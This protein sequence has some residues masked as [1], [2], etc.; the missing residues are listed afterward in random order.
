MQPIRVDSGAVEQTAQTV[1]AAL[2]RAARPGPIPAAGGGSPIDAAAT[3]L[4]EAVGAKVAT[5][6]AQVGPKSAELLGISAAAVRQLQAQDKANA[7]QIRAV[8]G[9]QPLDNGW[10]TG[11][12]SA[13]GDMSSGDIDAI[14]K[15]NRALLDSMEQEYRALPDGQVKTDRLADIAGIREALKVPESHLVYL[16]R[17]D[18]PAD[19]IP[20]ATAIGD[21][22]NAD[23]VSVTV[24]GVSGA[25]RH[26]IATMTREAYGLRREAQEIARVTGDSQN[27][28]TIAW[29]GYQP[30]PNL[31]SLQ[32]PFDDLAK[33]GAPKLESFLQNLNSASH[34]PGHT[35]ALF[36]HS[37]GSLVSGIALKDGA[38]SVVDN[39]VMY[40]SPGFEA[41]SPAKLGMNDHNFFVMTAP[42]DPIRY[43]A[44]L[45]PL[46]GWGSDPNEVI[47][48][49][50]PRYRF[51]HLDT[52]AGWV[53]LGG[54]Q[55]YKT[56][57]HGHSGY[58]HDP[59]QQMTGF[60]L[61][62]IL[63]NRPD[64]AVRVGPYH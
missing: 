14:D 3:A 23:H 17:P 50:G 8:A 5:L 56:G 51:T 48:G 54:Q 6:S 7:D 41:T 4:A 64:L 46:H 1:A 28:S 38:S 13:P 27:V 20:A 19:M 26:S 22:F 55:I 63:L 59:M 45:A 2:T 60:N 34:N 30:P 21:P 15:A 43:V 47:F 24:P 36:G 32:T 29:V 52:D 58:P 49:P 44:N 39:A 10:K 11:P 12:P 25:T 57:S 53:D 42:D 33:A 37:Y 9:T 35:T 16:A 61:A 40:G 31:G 18:N 62:T